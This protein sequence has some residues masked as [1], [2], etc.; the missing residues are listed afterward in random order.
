LPVTS[1]VSRQTA[2]DRFL[3]AI[4]YALV[5]IAVLGLLMWQAS[6]RK[7]PTIFAD[8]LEWT[9]ISRAIAATGHGA[10][11]GEPIAFKSVYPYVIAPFWWIHSTSTAYAAI[12]YANTIVMALAAIPA[13]LIARM[14]VAQR[15]AFVVALCS[16]CTTAIYYA[17]FL[18]PE[19]VAYPAF[20]LCAWATI[21]A[22]AR[23]GRRR[24]A[25]AAVLDVLAPLVRGELIVVPAAAAAAFAIVWLA[26]PRGAHL[27]RRWGVIGHVLAAVLV[28]VAF[29]VLNKLFGHHSHE[30]ATVTHQWKGRL[31]TLGMEATS[32]LALGLGVLPFIGGLASLWLPDR[33]S[34]PAWRAFA[35]FTASALVTT[36]TYTGVKAAYLSTVFATRVEERNLIY[37][38][39][40]LLAGTAAWLCSRRRSL[41]A[42]LAAWAVA[43]WLVL[44]YGY[45][46][47]FP[48]FE[49]PGYGI[50]AMA[51]RAFPW[52][53][54]QI[55][56]AL[57]VIAALL[58]LVILFVHLR[59]S[60]RLTAGILVAVSAGAVAMMLAGE[61]TSS[62]GS[63]ITSSNYMGHLAQPAD[64]IDRAAHGI[65]VTYLGQDISTGDALGYNLTEFWNRDVKHV[66]SLDGSAPGPGPTLTPDLR[67]RYGNLTNG[68]GIRLV[69]V[70][71]SIDLVGH[72]VASRPGVN[73]VRVPEGRWALHQASYGVS[74]DG[75]ITGSSDDPVATGRY[76]YF[77]PERTVGI[78]HVDVGRRGFCSA[79]APPAHVRIRVGPL[80]LN[81]Q[82]AP[83]VAKAAYVRRLVVPNCKQRELKF[84]IA[85]PVAVQVTATPLIHPVD[86][87]VGDS[88]YLGVQVGF[89]FTKR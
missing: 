38:Q 75:W 84:R 52:N 13:F 67:T 82:R 11:R 55:R 26:G 76:A 57:A 63:A 73:L 80:R 42:S 50:A 45:Q 32:A 17:P 31:W 85:P 66:W 65:P 3:A 25:V 59:R 41:P 77:G 43:T 87:N 14:L 69:L 79:A 1:L 47:D 81:E 7:T 28:I 71:T 35:A 64:W 23:G 62:R 70:S 16:I 22:L 46:L 8:E 15:I 6:I 9:Q 54:H 30:W 27:R 78:L 2:L 39:P 5:A 36:W 72:V 19:V 21:S 40:L 56:L 86:F 20:A 61:I 58:L 53:Q 48:Y 4:P 29:L 18:L 44:H 74:G 60:G 24:F 34:D 37:V 12:R 88:R 33:R 68:A 10:R 49:A 89:S 51:N 83:Y